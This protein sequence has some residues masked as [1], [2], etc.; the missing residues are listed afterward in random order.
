MLPSVVFNYYTLTLRKCAS[1]RCVSFSHVYTCA[2]NTRA[3]THTHTRTCTHTYPRARG[4]VFQSGDMCMVLVA[5]SLWIYFLKGDLYGTLTRSNLAG[6][7]KKYI[8][9]HTYT[10]THTVQRARARTR[11]INFIYSF[12]FP[13]FSPITNP[14]VYNSLLCS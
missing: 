1:A 10:H 5:E 12:F 9:I 4:D 8:Y 7:I 11:S 14:R 13:F 3:R 2:H 6:H